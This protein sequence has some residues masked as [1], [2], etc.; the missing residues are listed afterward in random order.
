MSNFE[1][2]CSDSTKPCKFVIGNGERLYSK[3]PKPHLY[4]C[5]SSQVKVF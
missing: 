5:D 2:I 4:P 1:I 3:A